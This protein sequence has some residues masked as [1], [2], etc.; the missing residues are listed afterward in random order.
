MVVVCGAIPSDLGEM[1]KDFTLMWKRRS[2]IEVYTPG[3]VCYF[4]L[5]NFTL[6]ANINILI[7]SCVN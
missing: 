3:G 1:S 7:I 2:F 6:N 5:F 4:T